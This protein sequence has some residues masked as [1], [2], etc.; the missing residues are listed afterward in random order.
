ML[1]VLPVKVTMTEPCFPTGVLGQVRESFQIGIS[2]KC[3]QS[4]FLMASFFPLSLSLF[5]FE[6]SLGSPLVGFSCTDILRLIMNSLVIL[7][8]KLRQSTFCLNVN[9]AF[10][11]LTLFSLRFS[12]NFVIHVLNFTILVRIAISS[13]SFERDEFYLLVGNKLNTKK[14]LVVLECLKD[15]AFD[16]A[17]CL[18][19]FVIMPLVRSVVEC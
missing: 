1:P 7:T 12:K 18:R 2:D 8:L 6:R 13:V 9:V 11:V 4:P 5:F 14:L 17:D 10:F 16:S 15:H 19:S 3:S